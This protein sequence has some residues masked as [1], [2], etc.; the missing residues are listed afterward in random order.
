MQSKRSNKLLEELFSCPICLDV[1]ENPTTTK[2]GHNFCGNC[3][4]KNNFEC[5]VCRTPLLQSELTV[6]YQIKKSIETMRG[7]DAEEIKNRYFAIQQQQGQTNNPQISQN[8]QNL[9]LN[10][11]TN[12]NF[13]NANRLS[14][15][16][17][18]SRY[19]IKRRFSMINCFNEVSSNNPR[20]H[21]NGFFPSD[22]QPNP[23]KRFSLDNP[24]NI[25]SYLDNVMAEFKTDPY[26]NY[27]D[28]VNKKCNSDYL[29]PIQNNFNNININVFNLIEVPRHNNSN[30]GY[31]EP[32]ISNEEPE[33]LNY[34]KARKFLKY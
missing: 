9:K 10:S 25:E 22:I 23:N 17:S 19:R 3:I 8:S 20:T 29:T 21:Q 18:T 11:Q 14:H 12:S 28:S 34:P 16:D 13:S 6:N 2:C 15:S 7:M 5:A 31:Q 27:L 24:R 26:S 1:M 30:N 4:K 32:C 33:F